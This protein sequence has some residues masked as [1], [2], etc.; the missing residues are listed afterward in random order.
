MSISGTLTATPTGAPDRF[1]VTGVTGLFN[2]SSL[3]G[4]IPGGPSA[5]VSPSG[6]W[7]FDNVLNSNGRFLDFYGLG[8]TLSGGTEAN[9]YYFN[10]DYGFGYGEK[11]NFT[12]DALTDFTVTSVP[13]PSSLMLLG[14]GALGLLTAFRRK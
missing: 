12:F 11:P 5:T 9:L 7:L 2:G 6:T 4:Q 3:E 14:S 8:F 13:E 1:L 10:G